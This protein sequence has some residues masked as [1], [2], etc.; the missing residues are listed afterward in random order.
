MVLTSSERRLIQ[1]LMACGHCVE[2]LDII[3]LA[4]WVESNDIWLPR[5]VLLRALEPLGNTGMALLDARDEMRA[6]DGAVSMRDLLDP[7]QDAARRFPAATE[8]LNEF[9]WRL[10]D[11]EAAPIFDMALVV[12]AASNVGRSFHPFSGYLPGVIVRDVLEA[13]GTADAAAMRN[14]VVHRAAQLDP[15]GMRDLRAALAAVKLS[16]DRGFGAPPEVAG[17]VVAALERVNGA[18]QLA[19]AELRANAASGKELSAIALHAA[20]CDRALFAFRCLGAEA[21]P[22]A[23]H[24][25]CL[26]ALAYGARNLDRM[27]IVDTVVQDLAA[28]VIDAVLLRKRAGAAAEPPRQRAGGDGSARDAERK[29]IERGRERCIDAWLRRYGTDFGNH[30]SN[31]QGVTARTPRGPGTV[32]EREEGINMNEILRRLSSYYFGR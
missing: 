1:Y 10:V 24:M 23:L 22:L 26:C 20:V 4:Q 28:C 9:F 30:W 14:R 3:G 8:L 11:E 31:P 2:S 18:W 12:H 7:K 17:A 6:Q 13:F 21:G 27:L 19:A 32:A 25:G 16:K 29:R 15:K 5:T